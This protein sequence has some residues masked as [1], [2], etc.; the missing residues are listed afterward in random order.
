[1]KA[2]INILSVR[3][4]L[5]R[6]AIFAALWWLLAE[7]VAASWTVGAV[8]VLGASWLSLLLAT[9][10]APATTATSAAGISAIG[11]LRFIPY[12]LYQSL[13]GGLDVA[14]RALR[15]DLPVSPGFIEYRLQWLPDTGARLFFMNIISLLPG[16]LSVEFDADGGV[17]HLLNKEN[18]DTQ[19]L[20][21]CER[22]VALLFGID[23]AS[24]D[25][26]AQGGTL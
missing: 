6:L 16:S 14:R 15:P 4:W 18:L 25:A 10:L 11:L 21:E 24:G 20:R 9:R 7:G 5:P 26:Q 17:V 22:R 8:A 19:E 13:R 3:A 12:F 1:M 2:G 23:V